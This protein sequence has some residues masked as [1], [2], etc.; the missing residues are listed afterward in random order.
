VAALEDEDPEVRRAAVNALAEL[1]DPSAIGPLNALLEREKNRKVP[2]SLIR[3]AIEASAT[4]DLP[5]AAA[6]TPAA[7][8]KDATA[9][10]TEKKD[11]DDEDREVFEI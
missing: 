11:K 6:S 8:A 7:T 4:I 1:R 9:T 10:S 2:H 5:E 3:R